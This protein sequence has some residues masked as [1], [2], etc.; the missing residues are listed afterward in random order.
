MHLYVSRSL[1][2]FTQEREIKIKIMY[3]RG[4]R[5]RAISPSLDRHERNTDD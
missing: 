4:G 2:P 1:F 5:G 3:E